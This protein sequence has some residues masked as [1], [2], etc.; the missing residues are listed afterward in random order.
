M[1]QL[2]QCSTVPYQFSQDDTFQEEL[3]EVNQLYFQEN[4]IDT[5]CYESLNDLEGASA[6]NLFDSETYLTQRV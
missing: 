6:N 4:N 5:F 2:S 1:S 3:R